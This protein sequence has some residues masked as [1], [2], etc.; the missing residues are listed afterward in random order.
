M[1]SLICLTLLVALAAGG[2]VAVDDK[3]Y[4]GVKHNLESP[5]V[6]QAT[7]I[8]EGHGRVWTYRTVP[9]GPGVA[10]IVSINGRYNFYL[11]PHPSPYVDLPPGRVEVETDGGNRIEFDLKADEEVF[12]RFDR[13]PAMFGRGFFPVRVDV[14]TGR[15]EYKAHSGVDTEALVPRQ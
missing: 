5:T 12:L 10:P 4:P 8:R 9:K 3:I 15:R 6:S 14:P 1:K 11:E 2:C 7:M 13:D